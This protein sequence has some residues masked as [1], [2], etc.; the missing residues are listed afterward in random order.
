M[1]RIAAC[2]AC[3]LAQRIPALEPGWE[4]RCRRCGFRVGPASRGSLAA[5]AAFALAALILY[6]PANLYPILRMSYYGLYSQSTIWDGVVALY[7]EREWLVASVVFLASLLIPVLKLAGL[8]FLAITARSHS[9]YW[10]RERVRIFRVI[11]VMGP[12][13]MLDVFLLAIMVGLVRLGQLATV[14]PGPGLFA[15]TLV[16]VCSTLASASFRPELIWDA[17]EAEGG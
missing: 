16:V 2:S 8:F 6:V 3:G 15:F 13:A 7:G 14:T 17:P 5:T 10:R 11:A 12:W 4:P 1:A 9:P